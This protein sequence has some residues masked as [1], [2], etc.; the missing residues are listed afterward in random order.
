MHEFQNWTMR[1]G[2]AFLH[3]GEQA[4]RV[5]VAV[6]SYGLW[7]SFSE[8]PLCLSH[9]SL[10]TWSLFFLNFCGFH[11]QSLKMHFYI[12]YFIWGLCMYHT[13]CAEITWQVDQV[14]F[15][16]VGTRD[17]NW[18]VKFGGK[19]LFLLSHLDGPKME[20]VEHDF[21]VPSLNSGSCAW[22]KW[23]PCAHSLKRLTDTLNFLLL[24]CDFTD[25]CCPWYQ[26]LKPLVTAIKAFVI[27]LSPTFSF[28]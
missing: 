23:V 16:Y 26:S 8:S 13:I 20:M 15:Y 24:Y 3:F 28:L 17:H 14:F 21:L 27:S 7:S 6:V 9:S 22:D 2:S 18:V 19:H 1:I 12:N 25:T 5:T 4:S 11:K 10:H